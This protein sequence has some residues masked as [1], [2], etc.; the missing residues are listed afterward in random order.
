MGYPSYLSMATGPT[1]RGSQQ[2]Q[3]GEEQIDTEDV[4]TEGLLKSRRAVLPSEIRRRERSTEDP[5]R[6]RTE[7]DLGVSR[8]HS[9]SQ[10]RETEAEYH[11]RGRHRGRV[12]RYETEHSSHLHAVEDRPR[13][14]ESAPYMHQGAAAS[15]G[16]HRTTHAAPGSSASNAGCSRSLSDVAVSH[17][18]PQT[19][20]H[21][22]KAEGVS[23]GDSHHD[24]RVSV[25]QLRHSY[26]ESTT[27]PPTRRRNEL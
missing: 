7:E 24:C 14:G 5:R 20:Y 6:G 15:P 4:K 27:T 1:A 25:A 22:P 16:Q 11:A 8:V 9:L 10:A 17:P 3:V 19:Q 12:R 23:N 21:D 2:Q 13:D 18:H 26:M